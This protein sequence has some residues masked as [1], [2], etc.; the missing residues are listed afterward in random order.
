MEKPFV[1]TRRTS[2]VKG[3]GTCGGA[4]VGR[5][6]NNIKRRADINNIPVLWISLGW[7][8]VPVVTDSLIVPVVSPPPASGTSN[9]F[10]TS[11]LG[12]HLLEK[13]RSSY[14]EGMHLL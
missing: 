13:S 8:I 2:T 14:V 10:P 3:K 7:L 6:E 11:R 5:P 4:A 12:M 9:L 1:F